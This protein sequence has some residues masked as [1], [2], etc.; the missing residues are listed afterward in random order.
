MSLEL[1]KLQKK[2]T[3]LRNELQS[4][5]E[6]EGILGEKTKIFEE[7]LLIHKSRKK[8]IAEH[9]SVRQFAGAQAKLK[10]LEERLSERKEY[11]RDFSEIQIQQ[12]EQ[13][14][15]KTA[16]EEKTFPPKSNSTPKNRLRLNGNL[17]FSW[18]YKKLS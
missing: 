10:K 11:P 16:V 2:E 9:N 1:K 4:L 7:K 17:V 15:I 18:S 14:Q 5:S 8:L 13:Q 6:K 3:E 12:A